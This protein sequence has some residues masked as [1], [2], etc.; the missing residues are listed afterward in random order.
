MEKTR[1]GA[2]L[3][4]QIPQK[5][6]PGK[7]E[8]LGEKE[9]PNGGAS[10]PRRDDADRCLHQKNHLYMDTSLQPPSP[11]NTMAKGLGRGMRRQ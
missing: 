3:L 1:V 9:H 8:M 10:P 4:C 5:F 6:G 2:A 11:K 7:V